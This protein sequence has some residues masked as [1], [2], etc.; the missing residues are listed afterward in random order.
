MSHIFFL[1]TVAQKLTSFGFVQTDILCLQPLVDDVNHLTS[2]VY[3]Y[4][5]SCKVRHCDYLLMTN[6]RLEFPSK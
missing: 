2:Q 4:K 3:H 1:I 5:R 6:Q